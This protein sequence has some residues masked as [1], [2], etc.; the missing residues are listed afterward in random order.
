MSI[1]GGG[2]EYSFIPADGIMVAWR[3]SSWSAPHTHVSSHALLLKLQHRVVASP[4]WITVVYGPQGDQEKLLFMDELRAIRS[5]HARPWVMCGDFNLI[6]KAEDKNNS[7]INRWL[8]GAFRSFLYDL[9]L[10]EPHL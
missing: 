6:Y 1:C 8:M 7:R 5:A 2:F 4:W 9:E 3:T 10:A